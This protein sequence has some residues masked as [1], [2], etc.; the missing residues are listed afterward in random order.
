MHADWMLY[1]QLDIV[2]SSFSFYFTSIL[3]LLLSLYLLININIL[4]LLC[5]TYNM[6]IN[7][8][9]Y[10][11]LDVYSNLFLLLHNTS[12]Y[13]FLR[14]FN[15]FL[16]P[17]YA[18]CLFNHFM[19]FWSHYY[20]NHPDILHINYLFNLLYKLYRFS[21][22][23]NIIIIISIF[24]FILF[25]TSLHTDSDLFTNKLHNLLLDNIF[26]FLILYLSNYFLHLHL[27]IS[28]TF[29]NY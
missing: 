6:S 3:Y 15:M 11:L 19:L 20:L 13:N 16:L 22:L 4:N 7:N 10:N 29:T 9:I 23:D 5:H 18:Y 2:Y 21:M 27:D 17:F 1:M 26:M 14:D 28:I 8:S 12:V 25:N 24:E